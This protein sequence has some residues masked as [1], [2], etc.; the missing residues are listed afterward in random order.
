LMSVAD[1][2][3][4]VG[5]EWYATRG[6]PCAA[7][8]KAS[9]QDFLV[10]EEVEF[11]G[12]ST[13]EKEGYYP[14]YRVEKSS[15]DTLHMAE[16][17]SSALRS[18]VSYAGLKDKRAASVQY[19]TPTSSRASRPPVVIKDRFTARLVGYLPRPVSRASMTGNRFEVILR[20]C[21]SC[22]REAAGEA[23]RAA[24]ERRVPNYYGLQRFSASG[25]GTHRIGRAI[26]KRDFAAAVKV[27]LLAGL[28][29]G[30]S[31]GEAVSY[32]SQ[33]RYLEA[34]NVLPPG[35]DVERRVA[36]ELGRSG[37]DWV[38]VLRAVPIELRRLY[39]HAYQS[40]IFNKTLSLALSRGEDISALQEGDNWAVA[41]GGGLVTPRVMGV[42][43][44]HRPG[45]VPMIQLAG[46]A[47]R[48]YGSRFDACAVEVMKEEGVLPKEFY[49]E[50]MQEVS[51]EGGF[52]RPHLAL[53]SAALDVEGETARLGFTLGRGQYA[54]VL[55]REIIKPT[56]PV[57]A[58]LA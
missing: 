13:G 52:R 2:E 48:D 44:G 45:A 46:Y 49:V 23:L 47:F 43:D 17:L 37:G 19:V 29:S 50:E 28:D 41:A 11:E 51:A 55:L 3:L 57:L 14:L 38:K 54:T 20:E 5:I 30:S 15:V 22:V 42:H 56:D 53:K 4:E 25:A 9:P 34:S 24:E 33:G 21:S 32:L 31:E 1:A 36:R 18:R 27:M 26:V 40:L 7:R 35:R 12:L 58:G 6:P 8:A 10:E 16:E 39:V